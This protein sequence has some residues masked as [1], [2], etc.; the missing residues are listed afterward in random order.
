[1]SIRISLISFLLLLSIA[2]SINGNVINEPN[3]NKQNCNIIH[4]NKKITDVVNKINNLDKINNITGE[5]YIHH[6]DIYDLLDAILSHIRP[7][8]FLMSSH[9]INY[10]LTQNIYPLKWSSIIT[11]NTKTMLEMLITN[12]LDYDHLNRKDD[13]SYQMV[14]TSCDNINDN[15]IEILILSP[16]K[17]FTENKYFLFCPYIVETKYFNLDYVYMKL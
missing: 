9:K 8:Q 11:H 10:P 17:I 5:L 3:E 1:M 12:I 13:F 15:N 16:E 7:K 14:I 4:F 2:L 6:I